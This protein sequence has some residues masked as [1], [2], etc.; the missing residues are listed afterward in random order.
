M[1]VIFPV[2]GED[3]M[4]A[5]TAQA[6]SG[7]GTSTY[8]ESEDQCA[9]L[10]ERDTGRLGRPM[11]WPPGWKCMASPGALHLRIGTQMGGERESG[12]YRCGA[13]GK[14]PFIDLGQK[15]T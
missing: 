7:R 6:E 5:S 9:R 11:L 14:Q 15:M 1:P 13:R 12:D 2:H 3:L 10:E 4:M 8:P